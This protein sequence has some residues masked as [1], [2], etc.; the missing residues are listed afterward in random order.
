MKKF[1][2]HKFSEKNHYSMRKLQSHAFY[3]IYFLTKGDRTIFI[4]NEIFKIQSDTIVCIPPFRMHKTEGGPFERTNMF[5]SSDYFSEEEHKLLLSVSD[6]GP[7]KLTEQESKRVRE[8]YSQIS[9]YDAESENVDSSI[10]HALIISL[11][12]YLKTIV[13]KQMRP[14][15][16]FQH[17]QLPQ[18]LIRAIKYIDENVDKDLSASTLAEMLFLSTGYF[19][20]LFK[21]HLQVPLSDYVLNLRISKAKKLLSDTA[22]DMETISEQTGFSSANYFSLIFK[23]KTGVSPLNFRKEQTSELHKG[24]KR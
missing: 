19:C 1:L 22:L 3:E 11:F 12:V 5:V 15:N 6:Y 16:T 8:F 7:I 20:K 17:A 13:T 14:S 2:F 24:L 9:R 21:K 18:E 23:K 10:V 4:N